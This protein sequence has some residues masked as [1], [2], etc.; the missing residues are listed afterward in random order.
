ML[1]LV[2]RPSQRAA[3][4]PA[5]EGGSIRGGRGESGGSGGSGGSGNGD[6]EAEAVELG[7]AAPQRKPRRG[8][9]RDKKEQ[10]HPAAEPTAEPASEPA[11]KPIGADVLHLQSYSGRSTAAQQ[12]AGS[13][14][15]PAA[16]P[17]AK[18]T[19][20]AAAEPAAQSAAQPAAQP[21][22]QEKGEEAA[23]PPRSQ[24]SNG[25][26][27]SARERRPS[28][29]GTGDND[30]FAIEHSVTFSK[31]RLNKV[32]AE[33]IRPLRDWEEIM[34]LMPSEE[35]VIVHGPKRTVLH[36]LCG[37]V[38]VTMAINGFLEG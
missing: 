22:A 9:W 28:A 14:A 31:I 3:D 19:A 37:D 32:S 1:K 13:A 21:A 29:S 17:V 15:E 35:Y 27:A 20:E 6:S 34:V 10:I 36:W 26:T 33:A 4:Q 12:A 38:G 11:T 7:E 5:V 24:S 16:E 8:S 18:P 25:R 2:D 23:A 30:G